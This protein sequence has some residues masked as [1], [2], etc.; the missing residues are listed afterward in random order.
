MIF[1]SIE[2]VGYF[3]VHLSFLWEKVLF[4]MLYFLKNSIH[5]SLYPEYHIVNLGFINIIIKKQKENSKFIFM[6]RI[7]CLISM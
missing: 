6:Q 3:A 5:V 1:T 7:I 2:L 4:K